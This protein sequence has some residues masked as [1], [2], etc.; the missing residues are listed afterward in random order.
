MSISRFIVSY[1]IATVLIAVAPVV[2]FYTGYS[3]LLIPKFNVLFV[4]FSV[5]T[6]IINLSILLASKKSQALS[7]QVFL[8]GTTVKL[9]LCMALALAYLQKNHVNNVYFLICF[10]YLYFLNTVFE[11]YTLLTNLRNQNLK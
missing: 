11:V 1:I 7:A 8:I 4:F 5:L 9:I 6:F 3:Y 10:F 2:L